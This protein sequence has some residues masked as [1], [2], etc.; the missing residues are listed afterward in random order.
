M[1]T[2]QQFTAAGVESL[3]QVSQLDLELRR[4]HRIAA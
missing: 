2:P 4:R 3:A 1:G